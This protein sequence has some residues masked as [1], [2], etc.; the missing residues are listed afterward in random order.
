MEKILE[1][2]VSTFFD[3]SKY[4]LLEIETPFSNQLPK[5]Q[6]PCIV[7]DDDG[8]NQ[9]ILWGATFYI[10]MNFLRIISNDKLPVPSSPDKIKKVL[11]KTYISRNNRQ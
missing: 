2:P 8:Q 5:N 4:A 11:S 6:F 7:L 10:M 3:S 1:I 9:D